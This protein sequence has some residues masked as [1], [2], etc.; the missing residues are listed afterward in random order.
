MTPVA[1]LTLRPSGR[2]GA[3]HPLDQVPLPPAPATPGPG[4]A[5]TRLLLEGPIVSTLLRLAA[6]NAIIN[7]VLI[8]VTASVDA[9]F[10]GQL[11]PDALAGLALVFPLMMLMQQMANGTMGS[12]IA[13]AVARALGGGR[14]DDA[15]ALVL[16][17]FVIAVGMAL[18]F[19]AVLLVA[20]PG[21]YASM[22]GTG[23]TLASAVEY[24]NVIFAG[25]LV[26]WALSAVTSV[27]RGAGQV[28][29][30]AMVYLGAEVLHIIL[31][32]LLVFGVGPLPAL[33]ITGA[34][35]ATVT[36]FAVATV[37]LAWYLVAG[38]TALSLSLRGARLD[39]RLFH[40]ILGVGAPMSLQ[41]VL[42]NV[43]LAIL[44]VFVATQGPTALA[45]FSAAVR[46]EY[47]QVPLTFGL[48][49]ALLAMAGTNI[50]AGRMA[51]ATRIAW[52]AAALAASV[53]GF[54]GLVAVT[55]PGAWTGFFTSAPDIQLMAAS[56]LCLVGL[57]YPFL[58]MGM[59]LSSA[60]Q[61][62]ARPLWPVVAIISRA[63][64]VAGGGLFVIHATDTGLVGL[65]VVAAAAMIVYGSLLAL[66][67]RAGARRRTAPNQ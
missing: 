60:F 43:T 31:V 30:L 65:G 5:R 41:P 19:T 13:S 1:E 48:G 39:R 9:H 10:V 22:G 23:S 50:G 45:G 40:D 63:V 35:L 67:F 28:A 36:S 27:M 17:G 57:T 54:V 58:G 26:Y 20:G 32:P 29:V 64:V 11:G 14:R 24:S 56:Y 8:A 34:G 38:R 66:A 59:T 55:W 25:A 2:P 52:T 6:P 61:A 49:A 62:A 47:V 42:N 4:A 7:V 33:G 21:L 15:A 12:A 18:A 16:H 44:T 53:T 3:V 46:L 51:R 37:F